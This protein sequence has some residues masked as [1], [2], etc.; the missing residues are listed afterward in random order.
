MQLR[1]LNETEAAKAMKELH[2]GV[3]GL[4]MNGAILA[5]KLMR[6]GFF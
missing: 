2:E 3:C 6:Q 4:H 5:K 1:C